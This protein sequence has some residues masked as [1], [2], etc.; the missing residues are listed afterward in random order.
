MR[1]VRLLTRGFVRATRP[2][3]LGLM[4]VVVLIVS[5]TGTA[6][7]AQ[8]EPTAT[9][10]AATN[11]SGTGATLQGTADIPSG[12]TVSTCTFYYGLTTDSNNSAPC[13]TTPGQG[14]SSVS[15]AVSGL[16]P[17]TTYYFAL[18]I[19]WSYVTGGT[20][21]A[22]G[23]DESFTTLTPAVSTSAASSVTSTAATLNG[24]VNPEGATISACMFYWG[25]TVDGQT[26]FTNSPSCTQTVGSGTTAVPVS[27]SLTGLSPLTTY[28]FYLDVEYACD[29]GAQC[30]V[31]GS[32]VSVTTLPNPPTVVTGAAS[33]VAQTTATLNATVNPNGGAV[34]TC[35]FQWGTTTSY[36]NT[37]SCAQAPG[38]GTSAV[39]VAANLTSL[40]PNTTYHYR[41]VAT[42]PGGT[43]DGTDETFTALPNPPT[44]VTGAA[45]S[46]AQ[47][48]ATL[49]ATVN[50]NGGAVS[51]CEFQWGTTTAYNHTS[52]CA[53]TVGSGTSP[54]AVTAALT[55]LAANT[56][57]H[58]RIVA[59]NP[60]GTSDGT[61][62][63]FTALPNPPTV[64]T[65]AAS[66][67]SQ[68]TATLNATVNPNGG[69]VSTCE[70][71]WGTT[72]SYGNTTSCAQAAGSGTSP[73][74]VSARL[75]GLTPNTI[76]HYR[77]VATNPGGTSD[78]ADQ[79]FT[80]EVTPPTVVTGAAS[81]V[82]ETLATV[83][84]TVNPDGGAVSTCDFQWGTTSGYGNV[85]ACGQ[86][87]GSGTSPVAVTANLTNLTPNTT[88]HYQILATN[89]AGTSY[90]TD[91]T[92][93]TP[94]TAPAVSVSAPV[95]LSSNGSAFSGTVNPVG[96]PTTAYFQYGLDPRY[97][98]SGGPVVYGQSTPPQQVGSGDMP[99]GVTASVSGLIPN[100]LYHV[101][102]VASSSAGTTYGPDQTFTTSAEPPPGSPTLGK[103]FNISVVSGT[104][105]IKINGV[106][107][108]LTELTQIPNNTEIDALHGTIELT[109]AINGGSHPIA[110]TAAKRGKHKKGSAAVKTQRGAF[111]GAI[112]K[113]SQARL[114]RNGGL[115]TLA[116]VESAFAGAP[117][118]STCTAHAAAEA[119]A[120]SLSS[121][122]L[123]L[124][125]ASAHGR[126]TTKGKYAAAT[127]RGTKWTIAD[128][129]NGTLVH[130][131]TDSVAV[132]DFV[133]H[134]TIILH[135]GQSYLASKP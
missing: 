36:G 28:T 51:T 131:L 101:R 112:F 75:T 40:N 129:C 88:Y 10:N 17:G 91:E 16:S 59:T 80:A 105:L 124:L 70:L 66:S 100:A 24:T 58:Y 7:M 29:D 30:P 60:G 2:A 133:H 37:T 49:N 121:K 120:A 111:G 106:F 32:Q 35:Q 99:V 34:S 83:S 5:A 14:T 107:V 4:L 135:A 73:V 97:S 18:E 39:P 114:G 9:T 65:G 57:Y 117:S 110:D 53:Q 85:I 20:G 74:A 15:A 72:T 54:V 22:D 47:T 96:L 82:S 98:G 115:V 21:I 26:S 38:S 118:Y 23:D 48:T 108:P 77:I 3:R 119:S 44:V 64:V 128:Q 11:V 127:V 86:T 87:V 122:T 41:I 92:F 78:G 1:I 79:M 113:I 45:S 69:T 50:P 25:V 90:G 123:Q 42:N 56:T 116:L 132:T 62:E 102:L 93:T 19:Q 67:V 95:V 104:V 43:S 71:Q 94:T 63:T 130:D 109:T 76:Y 81:G 103:T 46:I 134:K 6:A 27:V 33:S 13:S 8:E 126:F 55:G 89:S 84:A 31:A 125:R 61:D 52:A 12:Y 68:T